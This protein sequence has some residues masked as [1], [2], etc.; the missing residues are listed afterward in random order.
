MT[1]LA[2]GLGWQELV[3]IGLIAVLLFGKRLPEVGRSLGQALVEF[4]KGLSGV[5]DEVKDAVDGAKDV[6]STANQTNQTN[7]T[8]QTGQTGQTTRTT[9]TEPPKQ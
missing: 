9:P 4:K 5:K 7:Q 6:A 1:T 8:G 2:F 3:V